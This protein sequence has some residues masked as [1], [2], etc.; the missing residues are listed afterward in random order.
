MQKLV[1]TLHITIEIY[2]FIMFPYFRFITQLSV[3]ESGVIF[4]VSRNEQSSGS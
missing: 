2:F 3:Y 1:N 4:L